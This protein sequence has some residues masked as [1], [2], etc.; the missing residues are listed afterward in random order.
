MIS[1]VIIIIKLILIIIFLVRLIIM[2]PAAWVL[3]L[4]SCKRREDNG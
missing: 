4:E 1:M 3:G 2:R